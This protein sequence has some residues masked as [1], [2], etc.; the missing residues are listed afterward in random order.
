VYV[1]RT[2]LPADDVPGGR[3]LYTEVIQDVPIGMVIQV[4]ESF[5]DNRGVC[6]YFKG[7]FNTNYIV[8]PATVP[9]FFTGDY[10]AS[11]VPT[12]VYNSCEVCLTSCTGITINLEFVINSNGLGPVPV[13]M[14]PVVIP[15]APN[16]T[17]AVEFTD[18]SSTYSY[19]PSTLVTSNGIFVTQEF[20]LPNCFSFDISSL[21]VNFLVEP[22]TI[23]TTFL[24]FNVY[25]NGI[26]QSQNNFESLYNP[27]SSPQA[28]GVTG[29]F[30]FPQLC[31]NLPCNGLLTDGST[32]KIEINRFKNAN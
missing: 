30:F 1:Y 7:T 4:N 8:P 28:N 17:N 3:G 15:Q 32:L 23:Y 6:W 18:G 9:I 5:K 21:S 2:C 24:E 16:Y 19:L 27:S 31:N 29:F 26:L 12:T 25:I 13:F 20:V 22:N 10:F 11:V 14:S